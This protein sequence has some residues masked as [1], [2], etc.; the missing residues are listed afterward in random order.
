[1]RPL[2]G[3]II[4]IGVGI[5]TAMVRVMERYLPYYITKNKKEAIQADMEYKQKMAEW[6]AQVREIKQKRREI[7]EERLK[8]ENIGQ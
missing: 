1:M 5:S 4:L 2:T 8:Q 6:E 7:L 3:V